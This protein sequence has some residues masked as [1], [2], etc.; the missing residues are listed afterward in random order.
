[1]GFSRRRKDFKVPFDHL[2]RRFIDFKKSHFR[3]VK[4]QKMTSK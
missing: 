3:L 2:K 4:K 1:L